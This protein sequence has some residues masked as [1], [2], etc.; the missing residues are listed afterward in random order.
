MYRTE[1][2]VA[3]VKFLAFMCDTEHFQTHVGDYFP[4][5]AAKAAFVALQVQSFPA[6]GAPQLL[7]HSALCCRRCRTMS[8]VRL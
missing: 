5:D 8:S 1:Y 4:D 2:Q 3:A 6:C 7:P